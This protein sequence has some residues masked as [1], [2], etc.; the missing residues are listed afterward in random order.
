MEFVLREME[1]EVRGDG[2]V[3]I[4][5]EQVLSMGKN[6]HLLHLLGKLHLVTEATGG[7]AGE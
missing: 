2:F 1:E 4:M 3:R 7:F 5:C 6:V